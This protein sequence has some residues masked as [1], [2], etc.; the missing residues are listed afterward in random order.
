MAWWERGVFDKGYVPYYGDVA[1][2]CPPWKMTLTPARVK[3]MCRPVGGDNE[4]IF[5]KYLGV[6]KEKLKEW[7]QANVV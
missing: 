4:Y 2:Q 5:M 1:F 3:W 6:G 7:Q